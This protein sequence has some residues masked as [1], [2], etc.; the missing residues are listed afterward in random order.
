MSANFLRQRGE[1]GKFAAVEQK[2][3]D[4]DRGKFK[5]FVDIDRGKFKNFVD[6]D[7]G[8][9]KEIAERLSKRSSRRSSKR[10][11]NR[12]CTC[13]WGKHK[14]RSINAGNLSIR[15]I[16]KRKPTKSQHYYY[17]ESQH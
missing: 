3:V 17:E 14:F 7:R 2:F 8:K 12:S 10:S 15:N 1:R 4:I 5:N 11:S 16:I 13:F 9:L 6:I